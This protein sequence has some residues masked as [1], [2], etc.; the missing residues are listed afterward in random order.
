[1]KAAVT[2][3]DNLRAERDDALTAKEAAEAQ[4]SSK[5]EAAIDVQEVSSL[6]MYI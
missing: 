6:T 5:A 4:M 2:A 3:F 1:L